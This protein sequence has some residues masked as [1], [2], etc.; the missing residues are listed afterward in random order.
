MIR[1]CQFPIILLVLG[2][3]FE[4]STAAAHSSQLG[5]LGEGRCFA[6]AAFEGR[7]LQA[8]IVGSGKTAAAV[9]ASSQLGAPGGGFAFATP[10]G[11]GLQAVAVTGRREC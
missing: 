6:F 8:P 1:H 5:A 2:S 3:S 11:W 4:P 9:A 10:E 7:G